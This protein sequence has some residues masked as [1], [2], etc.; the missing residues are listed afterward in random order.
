MRDFPR[1]LTAGVV[2]TF[3]IKRGLATVT[4]EPVDAASF[5]L[6][7]GGPAIRRSTPYEGS[8]VDEDQVFILA[9]D[10][11]VDLLLSYL[12]GSGASNAPVKLRMQVQPR[13]LSYSDYPDFAFGAADVKDGKDDRRSYT[14]VEI[15]D[16]DAEANGETLTTAPPCPSR[17]RSRP[18]T[19]SSAR[20]RQSSRRR[21]VNGRAATSTSS[22]SRSR[23][24]PT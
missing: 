3:A 4:G 22:G 10:A 20:S 16:E 23:P 15:D 21:R 13:G 17:R 12:S 18:G 1:E 24:N 2:G 9:L 14:D 5:S 7:T 11:H 19:R 6:T 8:G